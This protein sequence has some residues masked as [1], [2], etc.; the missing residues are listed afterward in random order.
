MAQLGYDRF[1]V[2]QGRLQRSASHR[3]ISTSLL[4]FGTRGFQLKDLLGTSRQLSLKCAQSPIH[5]SYLD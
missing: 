1:T 4:V 5:P 3:L 2:R